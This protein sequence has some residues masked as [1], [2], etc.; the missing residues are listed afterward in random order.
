ME[1]KCVYCCLTGNDCFITFANRDPVLHLVINTSFYR[2]FISDVDFGKYEQT[3]TSG[4]QWLILLSGN[5]QLM[6]FKKE[7]SII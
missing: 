6:T 2:G 1:I 5:V 3:P 4:R 7:K